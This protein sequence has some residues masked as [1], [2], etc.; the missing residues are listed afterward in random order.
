MSEPNHLARSA[1]IAMIALAGLGM[2]LTPASAA[3][4][5]CDGVKVEMTKARKHEYAPLVAAAMENKV[6]PAQVEFSAIMESGDWSAAYVSTP[7]S[8]DGMMFFQTVNGKKQFRD[9]WGGWAEP[10]ERPELA[11]WAR[12]L[13]APSDLARCF[14]ET[15]TSDE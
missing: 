4:D 15:V 1:S 6:K 14:A 5:P 13:G 12:K 11:A 2:T 7:A 3:S 8:D 10:S 9:V